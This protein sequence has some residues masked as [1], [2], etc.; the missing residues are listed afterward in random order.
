MSFGF[1]SIGHFFAS[2]GKDVVKFAKAAGPVVSKID[3]KVEA[4]KPVIEAVSGLISPQA[5]SIEDAAFALFGKAAHAIQ[6]NTD[7]VNAGGLNLQLDTQ[8][9]EDL[10]ALLPAVEQFAAHRGIVKPQ[11]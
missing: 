4:N 10:K 3:A 6:S 7:A 1:V 5:A 11:S 9:V 8:T 2:V